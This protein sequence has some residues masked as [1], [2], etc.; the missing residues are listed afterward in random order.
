MSTCSLSI[1]VFTVI[2]DKFVPLFI[3]ATNAPAVGDPL[4]T[5]T[6]QGAQANK[7]QFDTII[8]FIEEGKKEGATVM[9]GGERIGKKGYFVAPTIFADVRTEMRIAQEEIFGRLE[10]EAY[11]AA[12]GRPAQLNRLSGIAC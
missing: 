12:A 1:K 5:E 9:T 8:S 11:F 6:F 3:S 2:S 4:K 7:R 10:Y